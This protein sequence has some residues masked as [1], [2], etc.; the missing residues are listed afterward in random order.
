MGKSIRIN[1]IDVPVLD[2]ELTGE[3]IRSLAEIP[4][5]RV[6]VQQHADRNTI[7]PDSA[8]VR[9][10]GEEVFTHHAHH[11]KA[12]DHRGSPYR[13]VVLDPAQERMSL[14]LLAERPTLGIEVTVPRLAAACTLGNLD[15]QHGPDSV[16]GEAAIEAA[17]RWPLPPAG[18]QLATVRPDLDAFGAM[19]VLML[20]C[21]EP[22]TQA[23]RRRA[24]LVAEADKGSTRTRR[25]P[26]AGR[27][28]PPARLALASAITDFTLPVADRVGLVRSWLSC[29]TFPGCEG[30]RERAATCFARAA[31]DSRV[32]LSPSGRVAVVR[33][34]SHNALSLGYRHAPVVVAENPRFRVEGRPPYRKLTVAQA[35]EGHADLTVIRER[36]EAIEEGWG[37]SR[38]ILGSPQGRSTAIPVHLVAAIVEE[39]LL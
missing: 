3:D 7:V 4:R 36:L 31:A 16:C 39:H 17:L 23:T 32:E 9:V 5:D 28:R 24:R 35:G 33:S 2:D 8:I 22:L 12:D 26:W 25:H 10:G 19:A 20:R 11:S 6:L 21:H 14:A 18:S 34:P 1:G 29:G 37:G 38:T 13:P 30:A 27:G 15:P